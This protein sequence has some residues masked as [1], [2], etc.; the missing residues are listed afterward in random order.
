MKPWRI[1]K[2]LWVIALGAVL[3]GI[4]GCQSNEPENAS[5]RPWNSPQGWENGLGAMD[6]QH[7]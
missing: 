3:A 2:W 1:A 4:C 7:E 6:T 5:V